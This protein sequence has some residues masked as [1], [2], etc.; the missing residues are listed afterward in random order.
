MVDRAFGLPQVALER[1]GANKLVRRY[2][3]GLDLLSQTTPT[4]GPYWYHHDGLG[5]VTDVTSGSGTS[6]WWMTYQPFGQPRAN[7]STS[8]SPVNLFRFTGE[9]LDSSTNLYHLRARQYD[10]GIGR[11]M[12]TDPVAQPITDPYVAAYVYVSNAPTRLTEAEP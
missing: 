10:P 6:L 3:Y 5:S 4:K 8:Q 7:A 12:S 2:A 1:D 11:F 9:Y